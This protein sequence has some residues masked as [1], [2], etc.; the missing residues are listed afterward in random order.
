[1]YMYIYIYI[2]LVVLCCA[3]SYLWY[4][5]YLL[6]LS[7]LGC[8]LHTLN[9]IPTFAIAQC[10]GSSPPYLRTRPRRPCRRPHCRGHWFAKPLQHPGVLSSTLA[11]VSSCSCIYNGVL[12]FDICV[13]MLY[14]CIYMFIYIYIC[15]CICW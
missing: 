8:G 7:G 5:V 10:A 9:Q 6:Y 2:C 12:S 1:M 3:L 4:L 14:M 13:C 11:Q 15:I